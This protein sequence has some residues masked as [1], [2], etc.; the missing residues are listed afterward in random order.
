M[1][2][3]CAVIVFALW[4]GNQIW[5]SP[6]ENEWIYCKVT[7]VAGTDVTATREDTGEVRS[8]LHDSLC[9]RPMVEA[10]FVRQELKLKDDKASPIY[11]VDG[12]EV[13]EVDNLI[14]LG[15]VDGAFLSE[16][17]VLYVIS[18]RFVKKDLIYVR[19]PIAP[20]PYPPS[21]LGSFQ[22]TTAAQTNFGA[23]LV[24]VN[25]FKRL[26]LYDDKILQS[27]NNKDNPT[28]HV[29]KVAE[30]AYR[31]IVAAVSVNSTDDDG[32]ERLLVLQVTNGP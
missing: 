16:P 26:P 21:P 9:F 8:S 17:N 32:L 3:R 11:K 2:V 5:G 15:D 4:Q 14:R 31:S 7:A 22:R 24:A 19:R 23:N 18:E 13:W 25:P 1:E 27:Y 20:P 12:E 28:P 29:F 30:N 10:G 6:A